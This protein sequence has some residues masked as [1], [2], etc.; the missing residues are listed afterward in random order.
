MAGSAQ[1]RPARTFDRKRFRVHDLG[2]G[3]TAVSGRTDADN[4]TL[5]LRLSLPADR[6]FH[7]HGC[8]GSHVILLERGDLKPPREVLEKAAAIAAWHSKARGAPVARVGM[9]YAAD[10]GKRRGA[11]AGE[12]T[13]VRE[14]TLRVKPAL[15]EAGP[16]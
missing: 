10:V 11:P 12:V 8:P 1:E 3:W 15:P 13:V 6:W 7:A 14:G 9:A 16:A 4:D 2:D 5:S